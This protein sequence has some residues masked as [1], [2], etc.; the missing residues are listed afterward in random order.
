MG[1]SMMFFEGFSEDKNIVKIYDDDAFHDQILEDFVHHGLKSGRAV[2]QT[3]KHDQGFEKS[4]VGAKGCLPLVPFLY[5]YIIISPLNIQL[6]EIS[7]PSE[8]VYQI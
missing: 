4:P 8:L 5:P 1:N 2:S 7:G 3:K 6:G